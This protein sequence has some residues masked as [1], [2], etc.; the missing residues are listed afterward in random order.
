MPRNQPLNLALKIPKKR[1]QKKNDRYV[2][3]IEN[4]LAEY[5]LALENADDE[6]KK[7]IETKIAKQK[8]HK[9]Q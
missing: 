6:K 7:G 3:Y 9:K 4:K 1:I 8:Q 2:A 5:C